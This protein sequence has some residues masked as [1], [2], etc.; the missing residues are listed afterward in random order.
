MQ[1]TAS[2]AIGGLVLTA[3][4][5]SGGDTA[6]LKEAL[7]AAGIDNPEILQQNLQQVGE[8]MGDAKFAV[9]SKT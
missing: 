9:N 5:A 1:K 7:E 8:L 6:V 2:Y 4:A 3:L